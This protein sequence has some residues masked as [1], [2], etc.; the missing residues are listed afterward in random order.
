MQ[1]R[2]RLLSLALMAPLA[3]SARRAR[4]AERKVVNLTISTDGD[5]LAYKPDQLTC[6]TGATVHLT[7]RHGGKYISQE[8]NWVLVAPGAAEAVEKAALAAGEDAGWVPRGDRRILAATPQCG[9]S[10]EVSVTFTAPSPGEYPFLCTNPGHGEVMH[11][12]LQ[13]TPN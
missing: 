7:F 3:A 4:S 12:I 5:L 2:R 13:V 10:H 1:T 8:H 6:P 11:G 9:K